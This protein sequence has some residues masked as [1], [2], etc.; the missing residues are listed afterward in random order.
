MWKGTDQ[1]VMN[2]SEHLTFSV[3]CDRGRS[4]RPWN[5]CSPESFPPGCVCVCVFALH[6]KVPINFN[7]I[8]TSPGSFIILLNNNLYQPPPPPPP[9]MCWHYCSQCL[10]RYIPSAHCHILSASTLFSTIDSDNNILVL[11]L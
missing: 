8:N 6:W 2:E 9:F 11:L 10:F 4:N 1:V 5:P 7:N 3:T